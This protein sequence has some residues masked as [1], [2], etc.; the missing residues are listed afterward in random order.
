MTAG[1]PEYSDFLF[2]WLVK[3]YRDSLPSV[4][5]FSGGDRR[6]ETYMFCRINSIGISGMDGYQVSVE[7]DVSNGLPGISMVGYLGSS[8]KEAKD[9]VMTAL[10]NSG[11]HCQPKKITVNLSLW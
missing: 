1:R 2:I 9:R 4:C 5:P 6:K 10:K 7:A 11:F 3:V 8:V